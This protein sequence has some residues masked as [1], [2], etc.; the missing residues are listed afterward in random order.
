MMESRWWRVDDGEWMMESGW[1]RVDDGEWM[2][3]AGASPAI[4]EWG[5]YEKYQY[6]TYVE[7][8]YIY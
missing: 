8:K 6:Q 2:M 4:Q 1:W 5:G 7:M 3:E